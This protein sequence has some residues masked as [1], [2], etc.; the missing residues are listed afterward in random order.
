MGRVSRCSWGCTHVQIIVH[1]QVFVQAVTM[2][3]VKNMPSK[4][5]PSVLR[6]IK[7]TQSV[8][9]VQTILLLTITIK[10]STTTGKTEASSDSLISGLQTPSKSACAPKPL[11]LLYSAKLLRHT[12]FAD[13]LFQM[14]RGSNF[15]ES[16]R[17]PN[18]HTYIPYYKIL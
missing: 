12:I 9:V 2:E 13:C 14:F 8:R 16:S 4:S 17:N 7:V 10:A 18:N 3:T 15:H 6:L 11:K 1:V 5:E